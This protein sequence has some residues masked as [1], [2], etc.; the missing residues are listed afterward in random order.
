MPTAAKAP[1]QTSIAAVTMTLAD[2]VAEAMLR[3]R[4]QW[5]STHHVLHVLRITGTI[6]AARVAVALDAM[7]AVGV[8]EGPRE[9]GHHRQWYRWAGAGPLGPRHNRPADHV[10]A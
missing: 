8:L 10:V 5:M 7:A 3:H 6:G 9:D 1:R 4:D 2:E